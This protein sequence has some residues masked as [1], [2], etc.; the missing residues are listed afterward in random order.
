MK[1][2]SLP[3]A[4]CRGWMERQSSLLDEFF[5]FSRW[6]FKNGRLA[7][8]SARDSGLLDLF[9]LL[10]FTLVHEAIRVILLVPVRITFAH[11]YSSSVWEFRFS[12]GGSHLCDAR[13]LFAFSLELFYT[14]FTLLH[15][16]DI[17]FNIVLVH[18]TSMDKMKL[19]YHLLHSLSRFKLINIIY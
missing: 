2:V 5:L 10:F 16:V 4:R 3:V 17:Q 15:S 1:R 8:K 7:C 18:V 6:S 12:F 19:I 14:G 9:R 13:D 11:I